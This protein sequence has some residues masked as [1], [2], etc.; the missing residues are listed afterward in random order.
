M[1]TYVFDHVSCTKLPNQ[2]F[3]FL[4]IAPLSHCFHTIADGTFGGIRWEE[5]EDMRLE[6]IH[7]KMIL[8][9]PPFSP[10]AKASSRGSSH[11][12]DRDRNGNARRIP[13]RNRVPAPTPVLERAA[14]L[15]TS[16]KKSSRRAPSRRDA[17]QQRIVWSDDDEDQE[18]VDAGDEDSSHRDFSLRDSSHRD[19]LRDSHKD[20]LRDSQ[21][22]SQRLRAARSAISRQNA[23]NS[24]AHSWAPSGSKPDDWSP[25]G[26]AASRLNRSLARL[27]SFPEPEPQYRKGSMHA[28]NESIPGRKL[29]QWQLEERQQLW[30]WMRG[31]NLIAAP[32]ASSHATPLPHYEHLYAP[33]KNS[34][35]F[36]ALLKVGI[37]SV[38]QLRAANLWNLANAGAITNVG[39]R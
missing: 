8:L 20:P 34:K 26:S 9:R 18:E 29:A 24:T 17:V 4:I 14:R 38:P 25:S 15:Q 27:D 33:A 28:T 39:L 10:E 7:M 30:D 16:Q 31:R 36:H 32:D 11:A 21:E 37:T 23:P 1:S 5:L 19:P 22:V 3:L 2:V 12:M 6:S 13:T 35:L